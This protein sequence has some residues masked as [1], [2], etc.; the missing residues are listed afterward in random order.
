MN[1]KVTIEQESAIMALSAQYIPYCGP[2]RKTA[3]LQE[4]LRELCADI[5]PRQAQRIMK[6]A[7]IVI[8]MSQKRQMSQMS[9]TGRMQKPKQRL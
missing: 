6:R 5:T 1:R 3:W 2:K 4:K 9:Q 8:K 7:I